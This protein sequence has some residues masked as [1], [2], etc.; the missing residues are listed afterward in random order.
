[1]PLAHSIQSRYVVSP[2]LLRYIF[3]SCHRLC[4]CVRLRG[5][6]HLT[7]SFTSFQLLRHAEHRQTGGKLRFNSS[8]VQTSSL[9]W[10]SHRFLFVPSPDLFIRPSLPGSRLRERKWCQ[11]SIEV[12]IS[13][14]IPDNACH[15]GPDK[16]RTSLLARHPRL[17]SGAWHNIGAVL[18]HLDRLPGQARSG[19]TPHRSHGQKP[20]PTP[21]LAH[22]DR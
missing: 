11:A 20:L 16:T 10:S 1:M 4:G 18:T 8:T 7:V 2:Q 14:G 22:N 21:Y 6:R 17:L 9:G 5:Y 15:N 3:Q 19:S 12:D 13:H